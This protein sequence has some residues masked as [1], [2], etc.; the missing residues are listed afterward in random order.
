MFVYFGI[1]SPDRNY[2]NASHHLRRRTDKL[3][4][5]TG[6]NAFQNALIYWSH[7]T[8]EISAESFAGSFSD[9]HVICDARKQICALKIGRSNWF[10]VANLNANPLPPWKLL[11]MH[12]RDGVLYVIHGFERGVELLL[13]QCSSLTERLFLLKYQNFLKGFHCVAKLLF[14]STD[15]KYD[16]WEKVTTNNN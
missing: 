7:Y 5:K 4:G 9:C 6:R 3:G 15:Y 16:D 14:S 1:D 11:I 8:Y 10:T 2:W 12:S 13:L